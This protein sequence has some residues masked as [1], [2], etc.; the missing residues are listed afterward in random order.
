[1]RQKCGVNCFISKAVVG[2]TIYDAFARAVNDQKKRVL[3][4]ER[5]DFSGCRVACWQLTTS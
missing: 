2:S 1:M 5:E 4:S 3:K